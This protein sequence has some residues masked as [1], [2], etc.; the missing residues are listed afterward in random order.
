MTV[1]MGGPRQR[2]RSDDDICPLLLHP[3]SEGRDEGQSEPRV[4]V[5]DED[6]A[7]VAL[8]EEVAQ[9]KRVGELHHIAVRPDF[10]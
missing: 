6:E 10:R 7:L 3:A 2:C 5:Q 1:E 9:K 8:A 4:G